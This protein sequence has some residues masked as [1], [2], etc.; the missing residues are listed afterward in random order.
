MALAASVSG[1]RHGFNGVSAGWISVE[2]FRGA[3]RLVF[4]LK[5]NGATKTF[6]SAKPF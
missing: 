2:F 6:L 5:K 3:G 4:F 1:A